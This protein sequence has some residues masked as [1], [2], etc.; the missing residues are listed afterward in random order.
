[1]TQDFI[2]ADQDNKDDSDNDNLRRST[3]D[4]RPPDTFQYYGLGSPVWNNGIQSGYMFNM[5]PP[6][7]YNIGPFNQ[8]PQWMLQTNAIHPQLTPQL[9]PINPAMQWNDSH[10]R[11]SSGFSY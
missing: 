4:R 10:P 1:M 11:M 8:P 2:P 6:P 3:R 7:N 5:H 9:T